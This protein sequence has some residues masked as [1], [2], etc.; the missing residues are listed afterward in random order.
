MDTMAPKTPDL[1]LVRDG[2]PRRPPLP[3]KAEPVPL[4]PD[5]T[6]AAAFRHIVGHC[7]GHLARNQAATLDGNP[8]GV[9]QMRVAVRRIRTAFRLFRGLTAPDATAQVEAQL[10]WLART[11]GDARDWDVF[12]DKTLVKAGRGRLT[13]LRR[14]AEPYRQAA[15]ERAV[16]EVRSG[17]Y[18]R[19]VQRLMVW[20]ES[21]DWQAGLSGSARRRLARPIAEVAPELL[22][23]MATTVRRRGRRLRRQD[24]ADRHALRKSL[25]KLR[26]AAEFLAGAYDSGQVGCFVAAAE[27]IQDALGRLN[28]GSVAGLLADQAE[29][30]AATAR[31]RRPLDR[32]IA[33]RRSR[34]LRRLPKRWRTFK[35]AAPFW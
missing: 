12:V 13:A 17:H 2:K 4:A 3:V 7:I 34:D 14:G 35:A 20:I 15:L 27:R 10:R 18:R 11:L 26:Y 1:E 32:W 25:K 33:K 22:D 23:A 29:P 16:D 6:T 19:L 8:E 30:A 24:E 21:D 5:A 28:D 31:D 9:H